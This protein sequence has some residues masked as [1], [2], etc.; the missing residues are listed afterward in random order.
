MAR[1]A[2]VERVSALDPRHPL[3]RRLIRRVQLR[4]HA[5]A[6]GHPI[7]DLRADRLVHV[8]EILLDV[9]G[10]VRRAV[11]RIEYDEAA[12]LQLEVDGEII[13]RLKRPHTGPDLLH[14]AL[15]AAIAAH[16]DGHQ[17]DGEHDDECAPSEIS[18]FVEAE[19]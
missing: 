1:K 13:G 6:L 2:P 7:I 9:V 8:G 19:S 5:I 16:L 17:V 14:P 3:I 15:E 11:P 18:G 10:H 4:D 12:Q